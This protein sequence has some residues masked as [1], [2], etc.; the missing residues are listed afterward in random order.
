MEKR[1][2][3]SLIRNGA[4]FARICFLSTLFKM[5]GEGNEGGGGEAGEGDGEERQKDP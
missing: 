5:K 4:S 3:K 1:T 2:N